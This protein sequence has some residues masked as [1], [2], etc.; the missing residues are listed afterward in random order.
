MEDHDNSH[1][2]GE[3]V[4][5][6]GGALEDDGVG[7]LNVAR[8]ARRLDADVVDSSELRPDRG[9]EGQRRILADG[10]KVSE[11]RH[12]EAVVRLR[13]SNRILPSILGTYE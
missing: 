10:G 1:E 5:S 3:D 9:A 13:C 12:R 6:R 2:E 4:R 11:A 8:V 7:Q